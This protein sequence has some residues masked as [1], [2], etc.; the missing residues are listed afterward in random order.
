MLY[1]VFNYARIFRFSIER[2]DNDDYNDDEGGRD[3]G[4]LCMDDE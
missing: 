2:D 3:D 4:R 1:I